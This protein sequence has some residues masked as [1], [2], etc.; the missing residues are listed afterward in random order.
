M[1]MQFIT[2]K[3]EAELLKELGTEGAILQGW[4]KTRDRSAFTETGGFWPDKLSVLQR[5]KKKYDVILLHKKKWIFIDAEKYAL[6]FSSDSWG[7]GVKSNKAILWR[8]V[9]DQRLSKQAAGPR[10]T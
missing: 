3:V 1:R 4:K 6:C 5:S 10:W 7:E 9:F 2:K 8:G